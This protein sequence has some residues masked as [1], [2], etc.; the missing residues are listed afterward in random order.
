MSIW[1]KPISL[2]ELTLSRT[3]TMV[4]HLGIEFVEIGND[5]LCAKMPVDART[6][7]PM[8]IMHGGAS[9]ALAETI[10][11]VGA[12]FCVDQQKKVCVGLEI[13]TSHIRQ[14]KSGFVT[15]HA[16]PVHLGRST[17]LWEIS[18][19]DEENHLI[20]LSRLRLAVLDVQ[21]K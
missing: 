6:H 13:N 9:C 5:Y 1:F 11:S 18:I 7:Q 2:V 21:E 14:V 16:H 10:A 20:S 3:S 12:N 8:G 4:D 19:H 17:Q 15:G